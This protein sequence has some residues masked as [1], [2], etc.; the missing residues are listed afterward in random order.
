MSQQQFRENQLTNEA[1]RMRLMGVSFRLMCRATSRTMLKTKATRMSQ[2]LEW[3][4]PFTTGLKR[5]T[6]PMRLVINS[7]TDKR[8]YTFRKKPILKMSKI[9][10][11]E[12]RVDKRDSIRSRSKPLPATCN[13]YLRF[14]NIINTINGD[15]KRV[16]GN[17]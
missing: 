4:R 16:F 15:S 13:W 5:Q 14:K 9:F 17:Y 1:K 11:V 12:N 8:P 6:P 10:L 7:W 3:M 2:G